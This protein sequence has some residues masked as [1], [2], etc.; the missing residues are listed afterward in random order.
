M[1][2]TVLLAAAALLVSVAAFVSSSK[3]S[4]PVPGGAETPGGRSSQAELEALRREV[5]MLNE[6]IEA[7]EADSLAP[8]TSAAP[9]PRETV[10]PGWVTGEQLEA[11]LAELLGDDVISG[12][13]KASAPSIDPVAFDEALKSARKRE[14]TRKFEGDLERRAEQLDRRVAKYEASLGLTSS[15]SSSLRTAL[16]NQQAREAELIRMWNEGATGL[17]QVKADNRQ[18]FSDEL[19]GFLNDEQRASVLGRGG[20]N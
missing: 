4:T 14:A 20:K 12:K 16:E 2:S 15:Q 13:G 17:G 5:S 8:V 3:G 11:R 6:R 19:G 10:N 1:K 18:A 9:A 7:L